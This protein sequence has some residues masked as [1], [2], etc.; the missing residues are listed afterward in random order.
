MDKNL[1]KR[2]ANFKKRH[3]L[4]DDVIKKMITEY[5]NSELNLARTYYSEKYNI[6]YNIFYKARDFAIIFCLIDN[7]TCEKVKDKTVANYKNNN[8]KNRVN[9]ALTHFSKLLEQRQAYYNSFTA[10]EIKDIATKY[11][12]DVTLRALSAEYSIGEY[13]IKLLLQKGIVSLIISRTTIASIQLKL[14]SKLDK[15]L[16]QRENNKELVLCCIEK[17]FASLQAQIENY[18]LYFQNVENKPSKET[19]QKRLTELINRK[20]EVLRY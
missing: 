14:G 13:G 5:A 15:F 12:K 17:E 2:F 3:L 11:E 10:E 7:K 4:T 9:G 1:A 18:N 8:P 19:L 20:K 6:S 16:S